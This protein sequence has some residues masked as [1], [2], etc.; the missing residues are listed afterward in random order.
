M[1]VRAA[2]VHTAPPPLTDST[3][4]AYAL[5]MNLRLARPRLGGQVSTPIRAPALAAAAATL[6]VISTLLS[7]QVAKM[8]GRP[9]AYLQL[10]ILNSSYWLLWAIMAPAIIRIALRVRFDAGM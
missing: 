6:S 2:W 3:V 1:S 9:I 5:R 7:Y 8:D 10:A 4:P